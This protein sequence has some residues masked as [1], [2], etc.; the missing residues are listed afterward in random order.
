MSEY[1]RV[2]FWSSILRLI[3]WNRVASS[4]KPHPAAQAAVG[5]SANTTSFGWQLSVLFLAVFGIFE[6]LQSW[7]MHKD[8][9]AAIGRCLSQL[10][11]GLERSTWRLPWLPLLFWNTWLIDLQRQVHRIC[12]NSFKS[13]YMCIILYIC[14]PH[15]VAFRWYSVI[16][17]SLSGVQP[18]VGCS[19]RLHFRLLHFTDVPWRGRQLNVAYW[20]SQRDMVK[21]ASSPLLHDWTFPLHRERERPEQTNSMQ[22]I[23]QKRW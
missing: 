1:V 16:N 11:R 22:K 19:A 14:Q 15:N 4:C 6:T 5:Q 12:L 7:M 3:G 2:L 18:A 13:E 17:L 21:A 23:A 9:G 20:K 10:W 8:A